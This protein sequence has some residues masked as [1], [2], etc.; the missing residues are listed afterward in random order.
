[1]R[2]RDPG[3]KNSD[4][5]SEIRDP[6]C[7]KFGSGIRDE[8][9][10]SATMLFLLDDGRIQ[11]RIREVQKHTDGSGST[12]LLLVLYCN[13]GYCCILV[14]YSTTCEYVTYSIWVGFVTLHFL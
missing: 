14:C 7:E 2:I 10:G 12:R 1:M 6:G 5:E 9:P 3:K 11:I 8:H 13:Y 4:S